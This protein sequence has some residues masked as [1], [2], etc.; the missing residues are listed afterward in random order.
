M[1]AA[2]DDVGAYPTR[3]RHRRRR[4]APRPQRQGGR[5]PQRRQPG[6]LA[7]R[8]ARAAPARLRAPVV[9]RARR[10]PARGAPPAA[11]RRPRRRRGRSPPAT[12][13]RT[14]TS[15]WSATPPTRPVSCTRARSWPRSA[16]PAA[17]RWSTSRSWT[18]FPASPRR[19]RPTVSCPGSW[20]CAASPSSMP[21]PVCAPATCSPPRRW[22]RACALSARAGR[23]TRSRSPPSRPRPPPRPRGGGRTR[24]GAPARRPGR[25][26]GRL[27]GAT[28]HAGA[29]NFVLVHLPGGGAAAERLREHGI[30][31][32]PC[33]S[34]PGLTADH[35]RLA[36]RDPATHARVVDAL[37]GHVR[38]A[39]RL[40][41]A[42]LMR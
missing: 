27:P 29:A 5:A 21:S 8:G 19:W 9:H 32:R 3:R 16:A 38:P 34:F 18:S 40:H 1:A 28:V 22:R 30:A 10:R 12:C 33:A 37:F 13:P 36:V 23:S 24:Y 6:L 2:L 20:C 35:L 11:P 39:L 25:A 42:R 15:S 31:V 41:D 17:S 4:R 26:P 14:P 7:R